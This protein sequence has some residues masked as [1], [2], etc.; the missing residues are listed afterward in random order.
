MVNDLTVKMWGI[1]DETGMF[2]TLCHHGFLLVIADIDIGGSY[3]IG[4]K[5]GTMLS[6][7]DLGQ[8][9]QELQYKALI[10]V[11]HGHVHNCICQ[12]SHLATYVKGMELE[13]LEGCEWFFSKF[14]ALASSTQYASPF[15]QQQRI[16]EYI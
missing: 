16:V 9:V 7:S 5:F 14:N 15:H 10:G 8:C 11:F 6:R 4:C 1:F 12:L 3:D 2:L 13:N